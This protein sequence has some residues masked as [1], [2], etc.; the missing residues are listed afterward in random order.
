MIQVTITIFTVVFHLDMF[1]ES[2]SVDIET[3]NAAGDYLTTVSNTTFSDDFRTNWVLAVNPTVVE[4]G[5]ISL[6]SSQNYIFRASAP[7]PEPATLLLLGTGL[8]GLAGVSRKKL[9]K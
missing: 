9:K 1:E 4:G 3:L 8:V 7:V 6:K 2:N 5:T